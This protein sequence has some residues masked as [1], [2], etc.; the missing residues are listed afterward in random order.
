[1]KANKVVVEI[2]T[3]SLSIDCLRSLLAQ[4]TEQVGLGVESGILRAGDGD[5]VKWET[6]RK[7]V[8]F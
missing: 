4:A 7:L 6:T 8:E 3:E 1:M 2:T 5:L